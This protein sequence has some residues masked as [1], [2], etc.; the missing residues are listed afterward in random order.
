[1]STTGILNL[2]IFPSL[3]RWDRGGILWLKVIGV[4]SVQRGRT[5]LV[6]SDLIK[7]WHGNSRCGKVF[8]DVRK[9]LVK[10]PS[11]AVG[12]YWSSDGR[13]VSL[14]V[15]REINWTYRYILLRIQT[16]RKRWVLKKRKQ[17][18][19]LTANKGVRL[20]LHASLKSD[21]HHPCVPTALSPPPYLNSQQ[22]SPKNYLKISG[23]KTI[24]HMV[25]L[26]LSFVDSKEKMVHIQIICL[27]LSIDSE[28]KR[29]TKACQRFSDESDL[30]W[31]WVVCEEEAV[32]HLRGALR[33]RWSVHQHTK[34]RF[35]SCENIRS[36]FL[37][38][39]PNLDLRKCCK[40]HIFV[41]LGPDC[42][43]GMEVPPVVY[44]FLSC[45]NFCLLISKENLEKGLC[46]ACLPLI[47]AN[48]KMEKEFPGTQ[49]TK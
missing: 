19:E 41:Q 49:E 2:T 40:I 24:L 11:E 43:W 46:N 27:K 13:Q 1:M 23:L 3:E 45:R 48:S 21:P 44:L 35:V 14:F 29:T 47:E 10:N 32:N 38:L 8:W 4:N 36:N 33:N 37:C 12:P 18:W 42:V 39:R 34:G 15:F 22:Y 6:V 7:K 20:S 25:H 28:I 17:T 9:T 16:R 5:W 31:F 26:H 30:I